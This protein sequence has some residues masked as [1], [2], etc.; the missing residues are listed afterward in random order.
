MVFHDTDS[1]VCL[2]LGFLD[3]FIFSFSLL[4]RRDRAERSAGVLA[5]ARASIL[6]PTVLASTPLRGRQSPVASAS[7]PEI[8]LKEGNT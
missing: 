3:F 8:N 5:G 7:E 6:V 2:T 1:C 4:R